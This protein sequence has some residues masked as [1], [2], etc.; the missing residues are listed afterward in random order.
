M[1]KNE[2]VI[3]TIEDYTDEGF[4]VARHEGYV[5]FIPGTVA[6]EEAEVLVVKAGKSFG[7]GKV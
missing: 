1:K 3:V 5:L 6:G 7:Y 4:G 2:K